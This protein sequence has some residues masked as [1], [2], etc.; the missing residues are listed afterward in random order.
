MLLIL[1]MC[2]LSNPGV[3][4]KW[5]IEKRVQW[6]YV[7]AVNH[8]FKYPSPNKKNSSAYDTPVGAS[9]T[10][11]NNSFI[12][13]WQS[14]GELPLVAERSLSYFIRGSFGNSVWKSLLVHIRY[15]EKG[16]GIRYVCWRGLIF[17]ITK[18]CLEE[19]PPFM[20]WAIFHG[21]WEHFLWSIDIRPVTE[22]FTPMW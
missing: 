13:H 16:E 15:L 19:E 14:D 6:S 10:L 21:G 12:V 20:E 4:Y 2:Y 22:F 1:F 9:W 7:D 18:K 5:D 17:T 11:N 3:N 8:V